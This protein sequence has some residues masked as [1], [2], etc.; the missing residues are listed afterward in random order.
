MIFLSYLAII[1]FATVMFAYTKHKIPAIK[2]RDFGK[3]DFKWDKMNKI[4]LIASIVFGSI[5]YL[6]SDNIY[7]S[8]SMAIVTFVAF[9]CSAV[10]FKMMLLP[11]EPISLAIKLHLPFIILAAPSLDL[12]SVGGYLIMVILFTFLWFGGKFGMGDLRLMVLFLVSMSWWFGI[13]SMWVAFVLAAVLALMSLP[14]LKKHNK[15]VKK[16]T[17]QRTVYNAESQDYDIVDKVD[18]LSDTQLDLMTRREYRKLVNNDKSK[19]HL[20]FGPPLL[21]AHIIMGFYLIITQ[22]FQGD[23]SFIWNFIS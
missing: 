7:V 9:F 11:T 12:V 6:I 4:S 14:I 8:C 3:V 15:T 23:I 20:P 17:S 1:F 21:I 13:Y 16:S 5:S 22:T 19:T 18:V 2:L 10:D